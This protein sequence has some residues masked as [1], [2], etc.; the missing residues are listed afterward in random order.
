MNSESLALPAAWLVLTCLLA[1]AETVSPTATAATPTAEATAAGEAFVYVGTYNRGQERPGIHIFRMNLQTG[2]LAQAGSAAGCV[3]PT[4][5]AIHPNQRFLYAVNEVS[6]S[7]GRPGGAVAAYSIDRTTGQLTLLNRQPSE[8]KGP[9]HLVVDK[10]GRN[11]LVA[12]Y[13][14]GSVG[15]IP[16]DADGTLKPPSC[17]IQHQ[18]SSQNPR[19]QEGPHAHSIN[20]AP[21]GRFALVAD[22]GIDKVM[23]YRFDPERGVLQP[24]DP[25]SVSLPPGSGPRHLAFHPKGNWV[26]VINELS[27]TITAFAY[28]AAQGRLTELQTVS[29]LPAGFQGDNSTA[30]VQ[31]HPSGKFVFGSNRGHHSLAI[32]AADAQAGRLTPIGHESTRGETPRN[33]ALDLTGRFILAQNQATNNVVVLRIDVE[34]GQLTATG[35]TYE[36]PSPV[37]IKMVRAQ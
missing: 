9:C 22:L 14:S 31:V 35:Q 11:V 32:F 37:C 1:W 15:V 10:D 8:G 29:T 12:N 16:I 30:E 21:D 7:G 18:G 13:G 6:D 34:T 27:S 25:D 23:I 20:L 24:N 17:A 3:N 4:F 5:L 26:Y 2:S 36:V 28:D 19:R 33:F